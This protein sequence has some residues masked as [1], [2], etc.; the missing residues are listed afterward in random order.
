MF[1]AKKNK[2][3]EAIGSRWSNVV[4]VANS[5]PRAEV[6]RISR[7]LSQYAG[8]SAGAMDLC[9]ATHVVDTPIQCEHGVPPRKLRHN[10]KLQGAEAQY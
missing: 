8:V 7:K 9:A 4:N 5:M 6:L 10:P 2:K 3:V 1:S